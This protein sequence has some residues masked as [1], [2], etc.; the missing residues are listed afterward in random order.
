MYSFST[1]QYHNKYFITPIIS[2]IDI[3]ITVMCYRERGGLLT[4]ND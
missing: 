4:K 2:E 3:E 1:I